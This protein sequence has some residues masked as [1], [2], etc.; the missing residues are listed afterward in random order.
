[1]TNVGKL[2]LTML[3]QENIGLCRH[4]NGT[5]GSVNLP[6]LSKYRLFVDAGSSCRFLYNSGVHCMAQTNFAE[7]ST[8]KPDPVNGSDKHENSLF[9]KINLD[10]ANQAGIGASK[11]ALGTVDKSSCPGQGD[12]GPLLK[13]LGLPHVDLTGFEQEAPYH[14]QGGA[15]DMWHEIKHA[16]VKDDTLDDKVRNH[17]ESK[18]TPDEH[19]KFDDEKKALADYERQWQIAATS[20]MIP[21]PPIPKM[22][23]TPMHKEIDKRVQTMEKEIGDEVKSQMSPTDLKRLDGQMKDYQNKFEESRRIRNPYGT[24]EGHDPLPTPGNAIK[25]YYDRVAEATER[26]LNQ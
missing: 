1:M 25:D 19:K 10:F 22:P 16:F 21:P 15:K 20:T 26:R 8:E 6:F 13:A 18:M 5:V 7:V 4:R 12:E 9:N 14:S 2:N 24:G 11:A 3:V 23:E 17:V